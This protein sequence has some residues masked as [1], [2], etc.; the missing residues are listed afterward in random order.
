MLSDIIQDIKDLNERLRLAAVKLEEIKSMLNT[1]AKVEN[2]K[3][4][5]EKS[6]VDIGKDKLSAGSALLMFDDL[7]TGPL[8]VKKN[9]N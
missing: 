8:K 7:Y 9:D 2:I 5:I 3:V 6:R 1:W 4:E